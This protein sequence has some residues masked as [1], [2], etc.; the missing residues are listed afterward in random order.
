MEFLGFKIIFKEYIPEHK[1]VSLLKEHVFYKE[2]KD[3]FYHME[4]V[5][6]TGQCIFCWGLLEFDTSCDFHI[7]I[8]SLIEDARHSIFNQFN[9]SIVLHTEGIMNAKDIFLKK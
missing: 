2:K 5:E 3:I 1:I 7:D 6:K 9:E 8:E 4:V